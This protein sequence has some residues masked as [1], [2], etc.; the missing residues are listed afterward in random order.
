MLIIYVLFIYIF[1]YLEIV[2]IQAAVTPLLLQ[3]IKRFI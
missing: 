2:K 1:W 3:S